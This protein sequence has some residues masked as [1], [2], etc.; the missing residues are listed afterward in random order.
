MRAVTGTA[1]C[2]STSQ[3]PS[4]PSPRPKSGHE[5][6]RDTVNSLGTLL[7]GLQNAISVLFSLVTIDNR[8]E[9]PP[10][11]QHTADIRP[12]VAQPLQPALFFTSRRRHISEQAESSNKQ[13]RALQLCVLSRNYK[14]LFSQ[15][16]C[17][18]TYT[19]AWGYTAKFPKMEPTPSTRGRAV[20]KHQ[21]GPQSPRAGSTACASHAI[22][23]T[24]RPTAPAV[25]TGVSG[26]CPRVA[27]RRWVYR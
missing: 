3:H 13:T 11:P 26:R 21:A 16:V 9:R 23:V 7:N 10:A 20:T 1:T 19:N 12:P 22:V 6:E 5:E 25:G 4:H 18:E 24:L 2:R 15:A 14:R 27:L 17:F 8:F